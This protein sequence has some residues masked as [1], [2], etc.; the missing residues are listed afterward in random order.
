MSSIPAARD[1]LV[2]AIKY[3]HGDINVLRTAIEDALALM[4]RE[5]PDFRAP[6]EIPPLT[7]E[8]RQQARA[9]RNQGMS[10]NEIARQLDTNIG[11]ISEC[12]NQ[13][14]TVP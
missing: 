12:I 8:Q 14:K 6:V 2:R 13:H 1:I 9:L 10:L 7:F 4:T 5:S 11:R 3:A